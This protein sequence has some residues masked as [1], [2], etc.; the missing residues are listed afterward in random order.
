MAARDA[1]RGHLAAPKAADGPRSA[2][3]V[4]QAAGLAA[5]VAQRPEG[6]L[7]DAAGLRAAAVALALGAQDHEADGRGRADHGGRRGA[8]EARPVLRVAERGQLPGV[9]LV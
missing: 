2:E 3:V 7:S 5:A 6:E 1:S 4:E 8:P 9:E